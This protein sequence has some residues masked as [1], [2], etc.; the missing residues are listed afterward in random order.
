MQKTSKRV[1]NTILENFFASLAE[2]ETRAEIKLPPGAGAEITNRGSG[3][4]LFIKDFKKF[5]RRKS[6]LLKKLFKLL[7]F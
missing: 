4:F 2:M 6:W 5:Y 7:Q 3:S 1:F